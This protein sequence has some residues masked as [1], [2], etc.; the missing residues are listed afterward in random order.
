M[1]EESDLTR[2]LLSPLSQNKKISPLSLSPPMEMYAAYAY[3][4]QHMH[5]C[6]VVRQSPPRTHNLLYRLCMVSG[7]D[8]VVTN[9]KILRVLGVLLHLGSS[10]PIPL[11]KDLLEKSPTHPHLVTRPLLWTP[12]LGYRGGLI[13]KTTNTAPRG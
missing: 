8:W 11:L 9:Y 3:S 6:T 5:L 12:S 7:G 2:L 4:A 13:I 1:G 10:A